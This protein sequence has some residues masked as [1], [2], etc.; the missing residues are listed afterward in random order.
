VADTLN[1]PYGEKTADHLILMVTALVEKL[2]QKIDPKILVVACNTAS[3]STLTHL[4]RKFSFP[5]VGVV[6]A[7]KP[8]ARESVGR[9][10]VLAT[11]RTV[12]AD[13]VEDLIH[14]FAPGHEVVRHG[15]GALVSA[16]E[17]RYKGSSEA[18]FQE[19]ERALQPLKEAQ[20]ESVVLGCTHFLHVRREIGEILGT[21]T[22]VIDSCEGVT[23]QAVKVLKSQGFLSPKKE[24]IDT[25]FTTSGVCREQYQGFLRDFSLAWGGIL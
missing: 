15:A 6:P 8:A 21:S 10:G 5:I 9:F 20:V 12:K 1:F 13:Y 16:V 3:V 14:N 19:L 7:V 23:N 4:R 2:L 18:L 11:E 22:K 24:G 17:N 25:F